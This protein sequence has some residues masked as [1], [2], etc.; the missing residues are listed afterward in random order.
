[1]TARS[2]RGDAGTKR[3]VFPGLAIDGEE[4]ARKRAHV[5]SCNVR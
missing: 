2:A 3:R 4:R 1:M 5:L